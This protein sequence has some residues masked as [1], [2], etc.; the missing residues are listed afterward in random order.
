[1]SAYA[2]HY[3]VLITGY[4]DIKM[5]HTRE[6]A[7]QYAEEVNEHS[8]DNVITYAVYLDSETVKDID[9]LYGEG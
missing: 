2:D 9:C 8:T 7:R 1:M 3:L 5:F 4:N 6:S